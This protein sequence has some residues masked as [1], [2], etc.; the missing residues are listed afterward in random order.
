MCNS[1]D[2]PLGLHEGIKHSRLR[3]KARQQ[4]LFWLKGARLAG[5]ISPD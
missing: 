5:M 2:R 3:Q 4:S 1:F